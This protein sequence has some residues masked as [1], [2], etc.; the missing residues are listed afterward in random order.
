MHS[1]QE[2]FHPPERLLLGPGPSNVNPRV[3]K[4]MGAPLLG[5]LD[6]DFLRVMDDVREMLRLVFQTGNTITFPVSGTGSA[7]IE[8]AMVNVLEAGDT[9]VVGV[10]GYFGDRM[11][12][13]AER[14]GAT[15][16]RVETEW[17][18]PLD[19]AAVRA[20]L[21]K[22]PK[23]KA[24]GMIHAETSTGVLS[25]VAEIAEITHA[26]DALLIVDTVTSLGGIEVAVD[27][28]GVDICY[29]GTQ[30]CLGCPPGLAPVTMSPKAEEVLTTR[31]TPVQSWYLD[32]SLL[33]SYWS[34]TRAYHHTAPISMIYG[35]REGLRVVL[36]E[37]LEARYQ[38]HARNALGLRA[39][40]EALGLR[41][42]AREDARLNTLTSVRIP[43]GISDTNVRGTLLRE[44]GIEIGGGLGPVAGKA[45]R[46][47]LMGENS[48]PAA[49]LTLLSALEKI[50]PQEGYEVAQ[51][52]GVGAA[53]QKLGEP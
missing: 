53:E 21:A 51:G 52:Q 12:Q 22:H 34:N 42:F 13:I 30:K 40:L 32:L 5:H 26:H 33:R 4:A 6:P 20:E 50:L 17:G 9:A 29:S 11:A 37:G 2:E 7:G 46:I 18:H 27:E 10:N 45:W 24:V 43:E 44:H 25:P 1:Y 28:W 36:E 14:C 23:V 3:L 16:H 39:G 35:L 49:V 48:K 38:R 8:T 47:G 31:K 41:L 19:P 15:V